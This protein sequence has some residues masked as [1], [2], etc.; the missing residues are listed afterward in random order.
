VIDLAIYA[1]DRNAK[2]GGGK[3]IKPRITRMAADKEN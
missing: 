3:Q 1:F 2:T